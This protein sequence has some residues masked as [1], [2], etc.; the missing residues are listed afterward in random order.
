MLT[1]LVASAVVALGA[2]VIGMMLTAPAEPTDVP[3]D[4]LSGTCLDEPFRPTH[5][6][7]LVGTLSR[8]CFDVDAVRPRVE[9]TGVTSGALYTGW[10]S[11][12]V[13][14]AGGRGNACDLSDAGATGT[15]LQPQRFDAASADQT[16]RVQLS[17]NLPGL[18]LPGGS[19]VRVLVID[20]GWTE[21]GQVTPYADRLAVWNGAWIPGVTTTGSDGRSQGRLV[22]CASF[23]L[24]G[25]VETLEQ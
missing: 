23:W 17:A 20:H 4:L 13:A 1:F 8:L 16:G 3:A 10:I 11:R 9:L 14:P 18:K 2:A 19:Q 21:S 24:R 7:V 6:G 5:G 25:G 22:G 12:P 15:T